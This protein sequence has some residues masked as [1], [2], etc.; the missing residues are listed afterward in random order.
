MQASI[1]T[2]KGRLNGVLTQKQLM[3][4]KF[5]LACMVALLAYSVT[6]STFTWDGEE[7]AS[8]AVKNFERGQVVEFTNLE[9]FCHT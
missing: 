7:Y 9:E 6:A 1:K 3:R 4:V 5:S 2:S 8:I